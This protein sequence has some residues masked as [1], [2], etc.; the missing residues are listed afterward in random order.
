MKHLAYTTYIARKVFAF[1]K[2]ANA[3]LFERNTFFFPDRFLFLS[4]KA[5]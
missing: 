2:M 4:G 3:Y 5:S 1:N